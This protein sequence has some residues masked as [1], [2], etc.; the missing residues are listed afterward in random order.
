[1][2]RKV[3]SPALARIFGAFWMVGFAIFETMAILTFRH[4]GS[5][6]SV[7]FVIPAIV[8]FALS[9]WTFWRRP[10][11]LGIGTV[12]SGVQILAA[13]GCIMDL[14]RGSFSM[15]HS[16]VAAGIDPVTA[17]RVHLIYSS[18]GSVLFLWAAARFVRR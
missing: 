12:L 15:Q 3:Y 4:A 10:W 13:I 11:A 6:P 8:L 16:F 17:L 1:M 14:R 9:L 18:I 5:G 2:L 7:V